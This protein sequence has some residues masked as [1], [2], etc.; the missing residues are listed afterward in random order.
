[1]GEALDTLMALGFGIR[2]ESKATEIVNKY[3]TCENKGEIV[4]AYA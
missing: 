2:S 4:Y 3:K 1:M